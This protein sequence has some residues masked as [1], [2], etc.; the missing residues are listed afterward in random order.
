MESASPIVDV[1]KYNF[2]IFPEAL[3]VDGHDSAPFQK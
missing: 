2:G 3:S 1:T